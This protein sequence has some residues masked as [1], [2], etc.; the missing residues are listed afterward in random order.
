MSYVER[1]WKEEPVK[2]KTI[3]KIIVVI[4]AVVVLFISTHTDWLGIREEMAWFLKALTALMLA[5]NLI[6]FLLFKLGKR[7]TPTIMQCHP[8]TI[9]GHKRE[10][11]RDERRS[12]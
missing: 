9:L 12:A 2:G 3:A 7:I 1:D 8:E 6:A 4:L 11:E 5:T 10:E